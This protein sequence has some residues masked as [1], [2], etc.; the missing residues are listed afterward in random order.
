MGRVVG[1]VAPQSANLPPAELKPQPLTT[2]FPWLTSGEEK[3][4]KYNTQLKL[5]PNYTIYEKGVYGK[6]TPPIYHS[7]KVSHVQWPNVTGGHL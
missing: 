7:I 2:T 1:W 6:I 4:D 3:S 5:R